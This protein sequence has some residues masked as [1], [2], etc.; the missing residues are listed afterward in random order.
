MAFREIGNSSGAN[1][2]QDGPR[3]ISYFSAFRRRYSLFAGQSTRRSPAAPPGI[4]PL[5]VL[6][7]IVLPIFG[8]VFCG[9]LARRIGL[10]DEAALGII[11]RYTYYF[12]LPPLL[13]KLLAGTASSSLSYGPFLA[14]I[15]IASVAG[16]VMTAGLGAFL[17]RDAVGVQAVRGLNGTLSNVFFMGIPLAI[18]AFGEEVAQGA[19]LAATL[20]FVLSVC[21][22]FPLLELG[23]KRGTVEILRTIAGMFVTNPLIVSVVLGY[24]A[25]IT[26]GTLPAVVLKTCEILG[27][28]AVPC[29]LFALGLLVG[30]RARQQAPGPLVLLGMTKLVAL[31]LIVWILAYHV[32]PLAAPWNGL[33]VIY[34]GLPPATTCFVIAGRYQTGEHET[35]AGL[36][37]L[38]LVSTITLTVILG[39][40]R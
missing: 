40:V 6:L 21:L 39:A 24:L 16:F 38:T 13:F 26:L 11:N 31:P 19:V 28:S 1:G 30:G 5:L 17:F 32:M 2:L 22:T 29:A 25:G 33:A 20:V 23:R 7:S 37:A 35:A 4:R 9:I 36:V 18:S 8:I 3:G 14:I 34:A 27:G 12:A 10:F 15:A